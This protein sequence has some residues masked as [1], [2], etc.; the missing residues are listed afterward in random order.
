MLLGCPL[1]PSPSSSGRVSST[2]ICQRRPVWGAIE[3]SEAVRRRSITSWRASR[4]FSGYQ[5]LRHKACDERALPA[6]TCHGKLGPR[7]AATPGYSAGLFLMRSKREAGMGRAA[8]SSLRERSQGSPRFGGDRVQFAG[9]I[10][11]HE[12]AGPG[13]QLVEAGEG[14]HFGNQQADPRAGETGGG[15]DQGAQDAARLIRVSAPS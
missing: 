6:C 2:E 5:A 8:R 13:A 11:L 9:G 1:P 3:G 4:S 15:L 14:R 12:G 10:G 7:L